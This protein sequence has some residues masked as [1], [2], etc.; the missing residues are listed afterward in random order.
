MIIKKAFAP[1]T[2]T[3]ETQQELEDIRYE[4]DR[5]LHKERCWDRFKSP[6]RY[7]ML[8]FLLERLK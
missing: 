2:I 4:L 7:T 3:I 8:S 1:I 6:D 5:I